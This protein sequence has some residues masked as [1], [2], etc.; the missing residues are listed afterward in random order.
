MGMRLL[1]TESQT[2]VAE[3]ARRLLAAFSIEERRTQ[4][5]GSW[6]S[7]AYARLGE[8]GMLELGLLPD[9]D[10]ESA[11]YLVA[12]A[13][14]LGRSVVATPF[15]TSAVAAAH[16]LAQS[17]LDAEAAALRAGSAIEAMALAEAGGS[18]QGIFDP[19]TR[20][21]DDR[22]SGVKSAIGFAG[23]ASHLL[24][25]ARDE[26]GG[27]RLLRLPTDLPGVSI[28]PL[29]TVA[30]EPLY[31]VR[32]DCAVTDAMQLASGHD[33][34]A[35]LRAALLR[36]LLVQSALLVGNAERALEITTAHVIERHQFDQPLGA[37]Q[38]VQHHVANARMRLDAG[39]LM[40][41][42]L[43]WRYGEQQ[44]ELLAWAAETKSWLSAATGETLRRAHE[45]QGGI[46]VTDEHETMLLL[47]RNL[48]ESISWGATPELT[49]LC[50][51]LRQV[52]P[53]VQPLFEGIA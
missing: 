12:F 16:C 20:L 14:E 27:L 43:A 47:R 15:A 3:S 2:M 6:L 44:P 17:G 50:Y 38:A 40:V 25:S 29:D 46:S 52:P 24:V 9:G 45:L 22:L 34:R 23:E 19:Q 8:A 30:G 41:H 18:L 49:P 31:E 26:R 7:D 10:Q 32:L 42:E 13:I 33:C 36:V 37:F 4:W 53:T 51:S 11:G 48:A 5:H 39:R 28:E 1:P 21:S 35:L